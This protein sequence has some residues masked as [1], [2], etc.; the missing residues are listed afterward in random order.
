MG[1]AVSLDGRGSLA[2]GPW[3]GNV[4]AWS[5]QQV[6]SN[7]DVLATPTV[8]LA[9]AATPTPTFTAPSAAGDVHFQLSVT[10]R[11]TGGTLD[12]P[13][14]YRASDTVKV[15]AVAVEAMRDAG[16]A[17]LS[18][19]HGDPAAP[20]ELTPPFAF[21]ATGYRGA[22]NTAV[23]RV[24]VHYE[25][26][27]AGATAVVEDGSGAALAD[28]DASVDGHQVDLAPGENTVRIAVT[29]TNGIDRTSYTLRFT[30]RLAARLESLSLAGPDGRA[31]ALE[32]PFAPN[33]LRYRAVA[34]HAATRVTVRAAGAEGALA[35][36]SPSDADSGSPGDQAALGDP[37]TTTT[38][39]ATV[40]GGSPDQAYRV[41]VLRPATDLCE[42]TPPVRDGI[43]AAVRS[44]DSAVYG[45]PSAAGVSGCAQITAAHLAGVLKLDFSSKGIAGLVAGDFAGLSGLSVLNL[46]SNA[47]KS[48]PAR[49]FEG[50]AGLTDLILQRNALTL[51]S[52]RAFAGLSAL[53][54]IDLG[55]NALTALPAGVFDGQ[56]GLVSL[57]L[58]GNSLAALPEGIFERLAAVENVF[59]HGNPGSASFKPFLSP[60]APSHIL[61]GAAVVLDARESL[62]RGPWKS[63]VSWEW[64][65]TNASGT[66][67]V[68]PTVTLTG[69]DTPTPSFTA[70]VTVGTQ[71]HF[72]VTVTGRGRGLDISNA[73]AK[74]LSLEVG[75]VPG[76][77]LLTVS[78]PDGAVDLAPPFSTAHREYSAAVGA[79]AG[80]VTV[81]A[82]AALG[83]TV[84]F[85][86]ADDTAL[87]DADANTT[88]HQVDLAP[89]GNTV[90][91]R[92]TDSNAMTATY[93]LSLIRAPPLDLTA[94]ALADGDGNAIALDPAFAAATRSYTASAGHGA[95]FATVRASAHAA[96]KV[97][98]VP[99]DA[100][101]LTRDHQ[102]RLH[103][104]EAT[105]ITVTVSHGQQSEA[106]TVRV[107]RPA[108]DV[109][110]RTSYVRKAIVATVA[111]VTDCAD[112]TPAHLA[113]ISRLSFEGESI[114]AADRNDRLRSGDFAGLAGL[115][116][117][118]FYEVNVGA[119]PAYLFEDL[120]ALTNLQI[121]I[122]AITSLPDNIFANLT[123]LRALDLFQNP[124]FSGGASFLP[125]A[126]AGEAR[127][128]PGGTQARLSGSATGPWGRNVSWAWTQTAGEP[129]ALE[130]ANTATPSFTA[131]R[132]GGDLTFSLT[133]TG[134][135]A[136]TSGNR[137][138]FRASDAVTMTARDRVAPSL[139]AA[140]ADGTS[141]ILIFSEAL[142][143]TSVPPAGAFAVTVDGATAAL[144]STDPAAVSGAEVT[145][146]LA[147]AVTAGQAVRVSYT[148]PR[149]EAA[150]P[151]RDAAGNEA[152]G[153]LGRT[154]V[155]RTGDS[156]AP[157]L[158][159]NADTPSVE[160]D[161]LSLVYDEA[162]DP[163]SVPPSV[164]FA[165]TVNG[166][167]V[168]LTVARPV[169]VS[170]NAV[171]LRLARAPIMGARVTVAYTAPMG[172]GATPVRDFAGN[173]AADL[174]VTSARNRNGAAPPPAPRSFA[175]VA[176]DARVRLTWQ[177]PMHNGGSDLTGYRIRHAAGASVPAGTIWTDVGMTLGTTV[178]GL[179]NGT[180]Y[181]FEL[182]AVNGAG[183][184]RAA[185][186]REAA[187]AAPDLAGR[188]TTWTGTLTLGAIDVGGQTVAYGYLG[189][190]GSLSDTTF[191][192]GTNL[193]SIDAAY[194]GVAGTDAGRL[195][196]S[197]TSAL[198]AEDRAA[199][200]LHVC[201][202]AFE[203]SAA[204]DPDAKRDY[205]WT[206]STMD[207]WSLIGTRMLRLTT[208]GNQAAIG[209]P[210]I[211]G[212]VR[213]GK[214]LTASTGTV[215][216]PDGLPQNASDYAWQWLRVDGATE[217]E[218]EGATGTSYRL[219]A[220]DAGKTLKVRVRFTDPEGG[221][222]E[223]VSAPTAQVAAD[224]T[225]PTVMSIMRQ[226]P[227]ASPINADSLTWRV[228]FSEEVEN[229]DAAD[230]AV[231]GTT[232]ALT[233]AAVQ[234]SSLA[235][236]V[237]ASGGDL[238]SLNAT[239]T[240]SFVAG[241]N[242][243]DRA[244]NA[245]TNT[246]P[247]GANDNTFIVDYTAPSVEITGVS[248]MSTAAFTA[249]IT[250]SEPVTGFV[251]A[252]ITL[253]NAT[254]SAFTGSDGDT[255]FTAL[256]TP[257]ADGAV[258]VDVAA[259]VAMDA[260]GNGN[261]AATRVSSTY[262]APTGICKRT[263]AVQTAILAR[264]SGVGDCV[265][266]TDEH[267]AAI[268]DDLSLN[269]PSITVLAAG[270]FDGL[271]A[272]T[273]LDL[274][275]NS[276]ATLPAG[277]FDGLTAL[278]KLS[279]SQNSLTTLPAG[280]FDGL[281]A[282]TTLQLSYNDLTALPS[283]AFD[284]LTT[285]E[286]LYL[287]ENGLPTLPSGV[288][289]GLTALR[290]LYLDG[291]SLTTLPAG[292]FDGL[293]AL[294]YLYLD[295]NSLTTLPGGVFD[296]LTALERLR[297]SD[298]AL[299]TLPAGVFVPLTSLTQLQ[300]QL[301][302]L[303][304]LPAGAFDN[305]TALTTLLLSENGLAT[306][307]SG[308]FDGLTALTTL[309]LDGNSLTTLPAGLF[310]GL[311][312]LGRLYLASN[313]GAP[314]A[315]AA[316]AQPDDGT[317]PV[318]G[319]TVTLD[320]SSSDGGPWGANVTHLWAL[321]APA[322]EVT[323]TF[324][325][326]MS[327]T[328][329]VTIPALTAGTGLTFT[330]TVTGRGASGVSTGVASG[331]DTATVTATTVD[332]IAPTVTLI[333]R[334]TPSA[335]PT[336]A[337][338]LTWRV[339]F[340]EGVENVDA[341]DFA[342]AGT[343]ATLTAAAVQGSSLAYDVTAAGGD[344][345]GLNAMV[346]LSFV[347]S[348]NI[349]DVAGNALAD[350]APTSTNDNTFVLDNTAP[351]VASIERQTP[352]ASSTNAE[353]LT[354]RV[355]FSEAVAKVDAA[356]FAIAGTTATLTAAAVHGSSLAYDV[357]AAGSDLGSLDATVTLSFV[358][359][360]NI[361]DPAGN[362]LTN[363]TPTGAN[364]NT[365]VVD[366]TSPTVTITDV[367]DPSSAAF[368]ATITF[369][370][371][372][373]GFTVEDI[374]V[375]NGA[376]S[377]FT[378]AD[379]DTEF[380][381]LIAPTADGAVTVDVAED[382][383]MD[384][385]G[386]GNAAAARASSIYDNTA[387]TVASIT[388]Q[389]PS[390][391]P[392]NADVLTWR[393]TFSE[394]LA[395]VDAADFTVSNTTPTPT[396]DAVPGSSLAYDVTAAGGDLGSLDATATL[397]F[398]AGQDITDTAGN[399][400][401]STTPT[402]ANENA[403]VVDN[404]APTVTITGVSATSMA[405][406]MATF[407]FSEGMDGF[408][409]EDI[410]VGNGTAS[411]FTRL[412]G[413]PVFTALITPTA[414]G[415]VTVDVAADVAMDA[416]GNGNTA[417]TRA[418]STYTAPCGRTA[419]VQ[420]AILAK[421][422]SVS[423][424]ALVTDEHLAAITGE[425]DL[426]GESITALA[427]GDFDGLTAL[428]GLDLGIN[429]LATLPAGVFDELTALTTLYLDRNSLATLPSGAFDGLTALTTLYLS[430]NGLTTLSAG[431][432]DG[433][434]A[435]TALYL[436]RNNRLT[437]LP[438]G[439]FDGLIALTD[440][441][442]Y[443][444]M[445]TTL[446]AGVF[447][448][449]TA[450][451]DLWLYGNNLASLPAGV[452]DGLT[453]LTTLYLSDN[454]LLTLPAG[455]FD[456]L[457]ALTDLRL[458]DNSLA[459][460]PAGVFD[461]LTALERL[462]L[463][464]NSLA[465]LPAEVFEGLT[466]LESL[467]L[468]DNDLAT[469][470]AGVF[471]GLTTLESLSLRDN[472]LATLPAGV[473]E[474]LNVLETL[475]L[476]SNPGEPFAPAAVALPDDGTVPAAGGTATL[477]G[478]GSGGAWGANVTHLWA[479]TAPASGVTVTF[480]DARSAT[481]TV[482]VP[483]LTAG[484]ELTFTLTVTGR[485]ASGISTGL[486]PGTDTAKVTA[487]V[488]DTIAPT[489]TSIVRQTPSAS[490]T[491]ADELTWRV[492]FS[493][494][495]ANVDAADFTVSN[496]TATPTADAVPGSS[497][498]YDVTASGG[499]LGSLDATVTLS[500]AAS[501]NIADAAGNAL[502]DTAPT[503]TND[504]TFV[505][506][507]TAPGVASI[508]RQTP[509]ASP[510]N[511]DVLTWR[512]TFSEALANVDAADFTIAGTTATLTATAVSG[513]SAHY[514]VTA[515]GGDLGSLDATVTL[516]FAASHNIA[517]AAGNALADT[518][519]TSTNDNTFVLDNTA[520]GVASIER[521]TPTA[522]PT[523]A[524][525]L[526][527][528]VTFSEAVAN[529]DTADF[530][531]AGTTATPTAD[532]VPGSS[533]AYDVTASGGDLGSLDATVTLSFAA[534]HNITDTAG[535][536]LADTAPTST[537]DNTFVVDNTSPTVTITD[538][539]DPS[540]VAFTAKITF[541]EGVDG[542]A[543]EDIA[544]GNGAASAFT[545]S[546]G[547][548][549]FTALITPTADG[550]VTVD[551]AA[552]VAMDAAGNGNAAAA[553]ASST[554]TAP[555]IDTIAPTVTSIVRQT[556][557][558]SPTNADELIWR[559][560]FSEAVANV[561]TADFAI[562]GTT[563]TPTADAVPGSSL[564]YDVT[565]SGGDLG[566][567][568]ATVTLSFAASHNITDTAGNALAD[569]A[570]TSTNDNTFVVDN[571][572]PGVASIERQTPTVSP[573]NADELIWRVTF[574]E[575]VANVDT[576]DFA[577]AGTTATPTADAVPGSSLAY[578]VT[579][580]GGD[581]GSLDATVTLSFAAS[582]NIT[583]TAGNA[584]AD[585]APTST[586]DNTFVVDNTSPTV[587]ITDV[588]DPSS[589]AFTAK[590]TFSEGVDGFAVEDI[591]VGNGAASAFTGS[592][593]DTEFTALI[594]PTADGEVTVDVAA[595]VAMDAAGNGNAAAARASST[596]TAP[597]IDTI[598]PTVTSIERQTPSASPTNADELIWRVTF[599]EDVANVDA[600]DF[601]VSN[602]TATLTATAVSGS[603]AH[604]DVTASGGDLGS[605]DATVTLSFAASHNIADA[606]GN[607]LADTAPTSTNDNT[608]VLDNT[609]PTVVSATVDGTSLVLTHSEDLDA[610]AV[611]GAD[612]F[613]VLADGSTAALANTGPVSLVGATLTLTLAAAATVS[614]DQTVTVT[615][616]APTGPGAAPLRDAAGNPVA[617]DTAGR[618]VTNET[619][620]P[621]AT[622]CNA[623]NLTGRQQ[624]W[625]G[626]L[627][628]GRHSGGLSREL[629]GYGWYSRT[630]SLS[631]RST[632]IEL[633]E[634]SYRIGDSVLL[635]AHSGGLIP[636]LVP[637]PGTLVFHLIG[638][639]DRNAELTTTER[640]GLALHVCD[641]KFDF[642][643]A[644]RPGGTGPGEVV[645]SEPQYAEYDRHYL[646]GDNAG[647][648]WSAG[649]VRTLTLSLPVVSSD[650]RAA[651]SVEGLPEM[652]G[653]GEDGVYAPGDRIEVRVRFVAPVTVDASGGAPTLGLALGGVRREAAYE[654]GQDGGAA[655]E[656]VFAL[657]VSDEDAGAGAAKA[658]ANGIRLNGATIRDEG[659][660]DAVL[661]YGAA[662]GAV[663]VE[664]G[665]EPS[666]DGVWTAGEAVEVTISFAEPVEVGTEEGTPS[667]GLTL[668]G[669]GGRRAQYA[670][671]SGTDRL[672]FVYTLTG[673]D[674]SVSAAL[675]DPNGL[676]LGGGTIVSTGGLDAVLTHSGAGRT[677][678][679]RTLGPVLSVADAEGA[680]GET[681]VFRV[682]LS[683][684][685]S[686][687][688]TVAYAT[689]DGASPN[690]ALAGEDYTTAAGTL[691]FKPGEREKTV[692][693]AVPDDAL[694]EGAETLI[695]G[696]S[697]ATGASI[698]DGE[699]TGTIGASAGPAAL[700][701][702]FLAVPPEHDGQT[703]FA[704][705]LR[706]SEEPHGLSYR[707]VQDSLFAV[708]G[709]TLTKVRRF[710]PPAN[711][712]YELTI[713]PS[714]DGAVKLARA[715]LPACGAPGA[716]CTG[717]GRALTGAL[718]LGV[719]GPA[720]LSVADA[721]VKEGP[722]ATLSF[723]VT[724]DRARHAQVT[725]DYATR[726]STAVADADYVASDGTLTFAPGEM[727]KTVEV[728]VLADDHDEGSETMTL[729]LSNAEGARIANAEATGTIHNSGLI[730]KAWIAR[731]GRTV[732]EQMLEAVEGRMRAAP[733]PG[734]EVSLAGEQIGGQLE[735]GS[736]AERD[737]R[738]E[739]QT[740]RDAQHR[741]R[742]VTPRDLLTGSAFTLTEET[743]AKDLVSFW[744][745]G[746]VTR[747]D[748]REGDLTLDGEVATG[749]LGADW[750]RGR[751]TTGLILS[752]SS[753]EGSYRD[754]SGSGTDTGAGS[755]PGSG[756]GTGGSVEATLT[757][758]FPWARHALSERLEAWGVAGY[759]AGELTVTP[760][761]P[762]TDEDGAVIRA[763]LDLRM[764]VMGLR[765][766]LL[767][768]G[769]DGLTLTA[770]TDAMVVQTASGQGRGA[771]GGNLES[772]RATVTRL[773]LGVEA[774]RPV[775]VRWRGHADAEP[776][777]RGAP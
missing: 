403:F 424:C 131:P 150:S 757:G 96:A 86:D 759:G 671:G 489:V 725:V 556:P 50:L 227:T 375:G 434:T 169:S 502:A 644:A 695:L 693:V 269:Q 624:V 514:D 12:T 224:T 677:A 769:G 743:S 137:N 676:A 450:L 288:F 497:L 51:L 176:G 205:K 764:A 228:T 546:D 553:R 416:A 153:F 348:Q 91:V 741:S 70:P 765:G 45:G 361:A 248:L 271:T 4:A 580:S 200:R 267:L 537:N 481:P 206:F 195:V 82:S 728:R 2:S 588:P 732:A 464:D 731:F 58:W 280:V 216:D 19:S 518:A 7:G 155:N 173:A 199:L 104:G 343:T 121:A 466:T 393:V 373:D 774:S 618:T 492:T 666:G 15:T 87:E 643:A 745:R 333:M 681:L 34:P 751:W 80:R 519:P 174:P 386:N 220:A 379:G 326:A 453:E 334:Q 115:T 335:S 584:L 542:F 114:D 714:G 604:Y 139:T 302:G 314:F 9:G 718:A 418:S 397:A 341:A 445:L 532:A 627:T 156:T 407:T 465:T 364:D 479:L 448:G 658:I 587:T 1:T 320:G 391:S 295:G 531:I 337:D 69:A 384:A 294:R 524:D 387:P 412:D 219:A 389:T 564:A 277:V 717:D 103:P 420:T 635:Y 148:V 436:D 286:T 330:L 509:T 622:V 431:V 691:T 108:T 433:L 233:A 581:L 496:T 258:T 329:A 426:N 83:S 649:L 261:T 107:K 240:L 652:T 336:N 430:E 582:H 75:D 317:I 198:A 152:A 476:A 159:G 56:P 305:L 761:K 530:A 605:L 398:A 534:S 179:A 703:P 196:F 683:P 772:A 346:T 700:T 145:L 441:W 451:T 253:T 456:E 23:A 566:S 41:E 226:A 308:V 130:G 54:V 182:Q 593:G 678:G 554:Y 484:T 771:D 601:V 602:T 184:G 175:A 701:A 211:A 500:F 28:A 312:A 94:L 520:P 516:S 552:D 575:A 245:L 611:P 615:Y 767:D 679:P 738:R 689:A 385:A 6:D 550:E 185:V 776:G 752:H 410:A 183:P 483:A 468:R 419:A 439:V 298:N 264:I 301:N 754:G 14:H 331:N 623:P 694:G 297:L 659:S 642:S 128:V 568:D 149:G 110:E 592:D 95:A 164:A 78:G 8:T 207:D 512:V 522:S 38:L 260:A 548:T 68:T 409:V 27:Q 567:L 625:Q 236:D 724:L 323:V 594:T 40:A 482:T 574:S 571:T 641:L 362:A 100:D 64:V 673:A 634:N 16:L 629:V 225:T 565:A 239:V 551:V 443:D 719:P 631:G 350:T 172:T 237:T 136:A 242:I 109:C 144:A 381:A 486:A 406:F 3:R 737:A 10:G 234:D 543:V 53:T 428:T 238:G 549:E 30:R 365:F 527:W 18:V 390:V 740:R 81:Q 686:G 716:I 616:T 322:S 411:A 235:Y 461:G 675:V 478:S 377:A 590:I 591:A 93:T 265:L 488:V 270:D 508:E 259:G 697:D 668:S 256:I 29:A 232:A 249:T 319:G 180:A 113:G 125:T 241:Q 339:T 315:P 388:R 688:V 392:T 165:V 338:E 687:P 517:D 215:A 545:G 538:V 620:P 20:V 573:T 462:R 167:A 490:P 71:L 612:A 282:L 355:T 570:P 521:Q 720:A 49:I 325:D 756:S 52:Q 773:R 203:L 750:R 369:T 287:S 651:V 523:N 558:V 526:I 648:N 499:D 600:A 90:K 126:E 438:A 262:T 667:V 455:V 57:Y 85:H 408:A 576:A 608:F 628:V 665:A 360:Q 746:V 276:L 742:A 247:T 187:C 244:G 310:E 597:L 733:A 525:E 59:L 266:V 26:R 39:M 610:A 708:S 504:N 97:V 272:L 472:D 230:F 151:L 555:L 252:E 435:L 399:A 414:D 670:T 647:L 229:V 404:T 279:L 273:E 544:V 770:K 617:S 636:L 457:T 440:L 48:L 168:A 120:T 117:L 251:M 586:N 699:A 13:V 141:A 119:L 621:D 630:G 340:S 763:D 491:N 66:P 498:A 655:T 194:R 540:S 619:A 400:L 290:Y 354:W 356:D 231:A 284:D 470:P 722:D 349:A 383:A 541:S 37:G 473:F 296:G 161:A 748:G 382:V 692:E 401:A 77:R 579:A 32:P 143:A 712:R 427:A 345:A 562:A 177:A 358:A 281:T 263:A 188:R 425:L 178:T 357:T 583:D 370:E 311:T 208:G 257:T 507:N 111:G 459:T 43:L 702:S 463:D 101:L 31:L 157:R 217:R 204:T 285:L 762:G 92:V 293:T 626:T 711:L 485:G 246:T 98:V 321:T 442:L 664:I 22:V 460:L 559:V 639:T 63:N 42:R 506:D 72:R 777:G 372:V 359:N 747:F 471:E 405:A 758:L 353:E 480:D 475:Y 328:P 33:T 254:A 324:D 147:A 452:F 469:L 60:V 599:S 218:I 127:T 660:A 170:G 768:G 76:L 84:A 638:A 710:E 680:E 572:S 698:G 603:S 578:D 209:A 598:A 515:S 47:L 122:G 201:G 132:G 134:R 662:P 606:A 557:S 17:R 374:A 378:G 44:T 656:L 672:S 186:A 493:E 162:L 736:E 437:T 609:A 447:D 5:W 760:K 99:E 753:G 529:V 255:E 727:A 214:T 432:L 202:T 347:A 61:P 268:T 653:P 189:A 212:T 351:G 458:Y 313:P 11:G 709:G 707:T 73:A 306:L 344:L 684:P 309:Y 395:N 661:D 690:G 595:D 735:P 171:T 704:V 36:V 632:L 547:D 614:A 102:V 376:A 744:G 342:I 133:V 274:R 421:I 138:R 674:G 539:P 250:F 577:I 163:Q 449:L 494:A 446:P 454:G 417:A 129:V 299:G 166:A 413:G 307:P 142:D 726:D 192:A 560:T 291:N 278:T 422:P 696:L 62:T 585:T 67:L 366:N 35:T 327:A 669:A 423:D 396:A 124:G 154:V 536:A 112:L 589:A 715:A 650:V 221:A 146:T 705:E 371:G 402:G 160:G 222:E 511:A 596:Y 633:G 739:E 210:E 734:V 533:L 332:N 140:A 706:F 613:A 118:S 569:T 380:T 503:S 654:P 467:S 190:A 721:E 197:L 135:G 79:A 713:T 88:G 561:D 316:V 729:A 65:Q 563:A 755:G 283:G 528:R 730:P 25:K 429:T 123:A 640:A 89:G 213:V 243:A 645:P 116:R 685:A 775:R 607:A 657:T 513:S 487:M 181:T 46:G 749:M 394:A 646:W 292:V 24:T 474:G 415:A 477:D 723:A 663:A 444:N 223:R 352:A 300:L 106:W 318:A 191:R 275:Y 637:A 505:L 368:T 535:N 304:A 495:V 74:R 766:T 367:P 363:T 289:N 158:D 303:T 55:G 501:H 105:A 510:T 193:Y 682:T 21:D